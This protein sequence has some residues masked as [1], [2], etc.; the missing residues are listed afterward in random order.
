MEVIELLKGMSDK[1]LKLALEVI[2]AIES[3]D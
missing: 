1:Q 2:R 3:A